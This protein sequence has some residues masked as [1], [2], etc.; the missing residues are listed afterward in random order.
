MKRIM[1]DYPDDC[2]EAEAILHASGCFNPSQLDYKSLEEGYHNG[3]YITF[4]NDRH[5]YFYRTLQGNYV[6]KLEEMELPK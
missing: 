6:L 3:R 4:G 1:I 5:A 2:P